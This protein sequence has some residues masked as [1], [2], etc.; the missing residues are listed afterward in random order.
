MPSKKEERL[1]VQACGSGSQKKN[2]RKTS[3]KIEGRKWK[4]QEQVSEVESKNN[5]EQRQS[6]PK[7]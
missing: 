5:K 6:K 7:S 1:N 3:K 2:N 4:R